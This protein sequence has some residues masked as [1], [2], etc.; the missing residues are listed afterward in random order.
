MTF[1]GIDIVK[2]NRF[3]HWYLYSDRMLLRVFHPQEVAQFKELFLQNAERAKLFLASRYAV[4][5]AFFK[6]YSSFVIQKKSDIPPFLTLSRSFFVEK[7]EN[8]QPLIMITSEFLAGL[9]DISVSLSHEGCCSSAVV[10]LSA[11]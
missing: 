4:K 8:N 2:N 11:C 5:E 7:K 1:V 10:V 3:L 6:A 9:H